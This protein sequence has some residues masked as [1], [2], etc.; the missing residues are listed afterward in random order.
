V[1]NVLAMGGTAV[2]TELQ[3]TKVAALSDEEVEMLVWP[4]PALV[5]LPAD[6]L[7]LM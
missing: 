2:E 6:V 7:E 5:E 1:R 3:S 4:R